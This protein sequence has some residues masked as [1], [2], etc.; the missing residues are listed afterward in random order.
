MTETEQQLVSILT[1]GLIAI[2][3][4]ALIGMLALV[5]NRRRRDTDARLALLP[6]AAATQPP[7]AADRPSPAPRAPTTWER[8]YELDDEP[9]GTVEYRPPLDDADRR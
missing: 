3:A 6:E 2:G 4:L 7:A 1:G 9:I 8:D 5:R